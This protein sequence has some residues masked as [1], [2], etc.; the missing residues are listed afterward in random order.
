MKSVR[1][2]PA[3]IPRAG[4]RHDHADGPVRVVA[5]RSIR[6]GSGL[7][8]GRPVAVPEGDRAEGAR[9][10]P[11]EAVDAASLEHDR[12]RRVG[13]N[14]RE[15]G[16][17][18]DELDLPEPDRLWLRDRE[19]LEVVARVLVRRV[20]ARVVEDADAGRNA[21]VVRRRRRRWAHLVRGRALAVRVDRGQ[22]V[23]V[24]LAGDQLRVRVGRRP[25]SEGRE[26]R[27]RARAR[28]AIHLEAGDRR[29]AVVGRLPGQQVR[30]S[31]P[32]IALPL[33]F[34][35]AGTPFWSNAAKSPRPF[36]WR[37][38]VA[39]DENVFGP[40]AMHES[41]QPSA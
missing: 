28:L 11:N 10:H 7:G 29:A 34:G 3:L 37:A 8:S 17:L 39:S 25:G 4:P 15:R 2:S 1:W 40:D 27:V 6:G 31:V 19:P 14:A 9:L 38:I 5:A 35:A 23:R 20:S 16:D 21:R 13:R 24:G 18:D 26:H 12:P 22:L 33:R 30:R 36:T 41:R 32:P